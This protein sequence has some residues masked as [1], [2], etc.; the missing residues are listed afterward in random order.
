LECQREEELKADNASLH[1]TPTLTTPWAMEK[2]CSEIYT[3]EVFSKFQEQIVVARY[4]Y[5]IQGISEYDDI[6]FFTISSL[7]GKERVVQM[8]K[9][10]MFGRCSCKFYES[11]GIPCCHIIQVL[12]AE[13]QNE[14]PSIY[15]M[16]RWEKRCKRY[17]LYDFFLWLSLLPYMFLQ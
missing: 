4:H 6:N 17:D 2:Q 1:Y 14:M 12:R 3:H 9:S 5:I 13:K 11:Y 16:K 10:N 15:I 8:N 7:S